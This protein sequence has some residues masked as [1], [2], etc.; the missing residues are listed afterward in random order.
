MRN[1]KSK[2]KTQQKLKSERHHVFT[3]KINNIAWSSVGGK[4]MQSVDSIETHAYGTSQVL[5][6]EKETLKCNNIITRYTKWLT[7]MIL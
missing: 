2:L 7:F 5:V 6:S 3:K 4:K 1:N